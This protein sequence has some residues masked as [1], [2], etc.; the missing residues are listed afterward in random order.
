MSVGITP[1]WLASRYQQASPQP[2]VKNTRT[3]GTSKTDDIVTAESGAVRLGPKQSPQD[4]AANILAHV[5]RGLDGLKASGASQERLQ[6]R[7]DAARAGIEKGYKEAT[8][9]L[10]G[11]GLLD[12][13]L[14]ASIGEGRQLVDSGID[15]LQQQIDSP[16]TAA[17]ASKSTFSA[18]N[19]LTLQVMTR[20]GDRVQVSFSQSA[21]GAL[22]SSS[23]NFRYTANNQQSWDM[24]VTGSLSEAEQQALSGLFE[25]V[26]SLSEQFFNGDLGSALQS[27]MSLGIDGGQLASMSLN[28]TQKTLAT[29]T[30][31]YAPAQQELPTP[32]LEAL[33][34]PL[35][36]YA[37]Q[38]LNALDKAGALAEPQNVFRDLVGQLLPGDSR[39]EAWNNFHEG[40]NKAAGFLSE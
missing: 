5:Q 19:S 13:D 7:L 14:K 38:Y 25:D 2:T 8:E 31:S 18:A 35:A 22:Q 21:E 34:A 29:T 24:Q 12:D 26:Q 23:G 32:E 11:M 1:G 4:T 20:E 39:L 28:L 16:Q 10:K 3:D 17:L 30:R 37:E 9:M 33:K 40:L 36:L 6:Q 15:N 27:A